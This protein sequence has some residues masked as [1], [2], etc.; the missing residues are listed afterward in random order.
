MAL[1]QRERD[2]D[3]A[4]RAMGWSADVLHSIAHTVLFTSEASR[5]RQHF[6]DI[7][8]T[9]QAARTLSCAAHGPARAKQVRVIAELAQLAGR[10]PAEVLKAVG[11]G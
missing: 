7:Q 9:R 11:R 8:S 3:R 4:V 6:A 2:V 1:T 10:N 5:V